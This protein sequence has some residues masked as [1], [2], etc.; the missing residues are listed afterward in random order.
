M[1]MSDFHPE[2]WNP[3]WNVH[4]I[5]IG[6]ISFMCDEERTTGCV[7]TSDAQKRD[8]AAKSLDFAQS[9]KVFHE[10]FGE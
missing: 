6:L 4:T 7:I 2:T 1:S 5:I 10:L 3:L 8:L 9:Q